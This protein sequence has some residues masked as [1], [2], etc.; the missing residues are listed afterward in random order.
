MKIYIVVTDF[1][2]D[3]FL[4]EML[5]HHVMM[6]MCGHNT[7]NY[8]TLSIGKQRCH[9]INVTSNS[10]YSCLSEFLFSRLDLGNT[11]K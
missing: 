4:A 5:I 1:V 7:F 2:N 11:C 8:M 3:V 9:M 10:M 6:M